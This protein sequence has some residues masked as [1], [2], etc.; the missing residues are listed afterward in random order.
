MSLLSLATA[1]IL[2]S[3][4]MP[5]AAGTLNI[6]SVI[7]DMSQPSE[8]MVIDPRFGWQ[9]FPGVIQ[10]APKGTIL[11]SWWTGNRPEWCYRSLTWYTAFEA[12]GNSASNTRVQVRNLRMYILSNASRTWEQ[13]DA[14]TAPAGDLWKYPFTYVASFASSGTRTETTGGYSVKPVY[15]YFHHGYGTGYTIANPEDI[16]AV[17]VAMDFRLVVDDPN[18][19]DDRGMAKYVVDVGADYY[20]GQGLSWGVGYA[21]GIGNGRYLLVTNDWRTGTLLVPNPLLGATMDEMRLN[22]PPM[23]TSY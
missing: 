13:V 18:K 19:A 11:P 22:S 14:T 9:K 8:A 7:Y 4:V 15:P 17:Y 20:P 6:D 21:P 1:S 23:T 5:A 2:T 16:R 3:V 10:Y 12:E